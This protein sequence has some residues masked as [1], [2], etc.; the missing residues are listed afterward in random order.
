M[1]IK[2]YDIFNKVLNVS[3]PDRNSIP[4]E[5]NLNIQL[6]LRLNKAFPIYDNKNAKTNE[7]DAISPLKINVCKLTFNIDSIKTSI[8]LSNDQSSWRKGSNVVL[9]KGISKQDIEFLSKWKNNRSLSIGFKTKGFAEVDGSIVEFDL[10]L[11]INQFKLGIDDFESIFL[12]NTGLQYTY[13]R[14]F[15]LHSPLIDNLKSK[16]ALDELYDYICDLQNNLEQALRALRVS[17]NAQ[18]LTLI[19]PPLDGIRDFRDNNPTLIE[20]MS[21]E[22][23]VDT[24]IITDLSQQSAGAKDAAKEIVQ[25]L[26]RIFDILHDISSKSIHTKTKKRKNQPALLY[27]MNPD[28]HDAEFSLTLALTI[29]NYLI[30]RIKHSCNT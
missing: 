26:F 10:E 7:V 9:F 24:S 5:K 14:E 20:D 6:T 8:D 12:R 11:P 27:E 19:R 30:D 18:V 21:K 25:N 13:T 23:Y 15:G 4:S 3:P 28:N 17:N 29:T 16:P 1:I 22:L 2:S